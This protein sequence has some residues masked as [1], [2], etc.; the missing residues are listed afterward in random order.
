MT[1]VLIDTEYDEYSVWIYCLWTVTN[2]YNCIYLEMWWLCLY[3]YYCQCHVNVLILHLFQ[4][5]EENFIRSEQY[6]LSNL[7]Y[8]HC[9][10]VNSH[11]VRRS[12]DGLV[13]KFSIHGQHHR[14]QQ[15][16]NLTSKFLASPFFKDHDEVRICYADGLVF[17]L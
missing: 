11:N 10:A 16:Q 8:H 13:L 9:L 15:L 14:A 4:E 12:I 17:L 6:V 3:F 2:V 7:L 5:G 1:N